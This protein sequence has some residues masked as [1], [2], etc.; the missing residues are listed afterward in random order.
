M[1]K[2]IGKDCKVALGSSKILGMGTWS[3]NGITS[4]QIESSEFDQNWKTYEFGMKDGGDIGFD[5]FFD[6]AD[7]TGQE[8]LRQANLANTDVTNLRLYVD[9]T[10]YYEPCRTTGYF[11]PWL[12]SGADT[13]LSCVNITSYDIGSDKSGLMTM[14]FK[15]KVS[16]VMVLV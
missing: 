4:D 7:N 8:A 12:T 13:M 1:G 6:G 11:S 2:K 10:S 14:S 5:G 15:G 3:L 9:K 16:G